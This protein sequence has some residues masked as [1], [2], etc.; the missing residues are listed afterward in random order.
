MRNRARYKSI[1]ADFELVVWAVMT[2]L[3]SP[4]LFLPALPVI[5]K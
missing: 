2:E 4:R 3:V 5:L 1:A